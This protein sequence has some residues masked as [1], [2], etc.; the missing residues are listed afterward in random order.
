MKKTIG[1]L[2]I[3]GGYAWNIISLAQSLQHEVLLVANME[4]PGD[5]HLSKYVNIESLQDS[6]KLL[7]FFLGVVRPGS[8]RFLIKEGLGYGLTFGDKLIS[9]SAHIGAKVGLQDGVIVRQFASLDACSVV[10]EHTTLS[11]LSSVGHHTSI[12]SYCHIANG[13]NISG[14]C[15]IGDD[16]FIGAGAI[17]RDS[18]SI[19]AGATIGMGAV[20]VRDVPA[21]ATVVGNPARVL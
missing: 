14:D 2:G 16:V 6:Q 9:P 5:L 18:I 19:G 12:G 21:G 15:I 4:V 7:P 13:A 3:S 1:I 11:P 10:G 8:K 17:I 20:V